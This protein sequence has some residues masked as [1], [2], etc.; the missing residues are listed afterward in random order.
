[1]FFFFNKHSQIL[2]SYHAHL[3]LS[4]VVSV[5]LRCRYYW[6]DHNINVAAM[7]TDV[8]LKLQRSATQQEW[9]LPISESWIATQISVD[10]NEFLNTSVHIYIKYK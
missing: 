3:S 7:S 2:I 8:T 1:M 9:S 4:Y 6:L 5:T 10:C